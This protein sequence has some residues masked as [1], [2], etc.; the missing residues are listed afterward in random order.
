MS[1]TTKRYLRFGVCTGSNTEYYRDRTRKFRRRYRHI[2]R[3][4]FSKY[5]VEEVS[6]RILNPKFPKRNNLLEPTDGTHLITAR[7][8]EEESEYYKE[9][10]RTLRYFKNKKKRK[11]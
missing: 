6:E 1:K 8:A 11:K 9:I 5:N 3:N 10:K 7:N 2:M 4:L